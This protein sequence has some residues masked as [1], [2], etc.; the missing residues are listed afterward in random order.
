M[1]QRARPVFAQQRSDEVAVPDVPAH[2]GV[3]RVIGERR[4]VAEVAR[5]G[6]LV[7]I[8]DGIP[9]GREP[10]EHEIGADEAG[11]AGDE[12]HGVA[13]ER[14]RPPECYTGGP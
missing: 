8:D 12:D 2:E 13:S 14:C 1:V 9:A 3:A 11:A 7:E 6:E 5:V 10:I 4:Q